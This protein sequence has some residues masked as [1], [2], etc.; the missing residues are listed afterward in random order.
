MGNRDSCQ[1]RD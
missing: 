1:Y